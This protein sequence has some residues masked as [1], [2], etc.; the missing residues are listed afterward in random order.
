MKYLFSF[1]L[2]VVLFYFFKFITFDMHLDSYVSVNIK[3]CGP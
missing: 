3:I 2:E 1:K